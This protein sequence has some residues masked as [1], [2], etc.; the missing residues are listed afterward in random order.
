MSSRSLRLHCFFPSLNFARK[1]CL[2]KGRRGVSRENPDGA[3]LGCFL[4]SFR[5]VSPRYRADHLSRSAALL[6]PL[7]ATPS[8]PTV[9]VVVVVFFLSPHTFHSGLASSPP[10]ARPPKTQIPARCGVLREL[11]WRRRRSLHTQANL[12]F[13]RMFRGWW[14]LPGVPAAAPSPPPSILSFSGQTR[15]IE[16]RAPPETIDDIVDQ[17]DGPSDSNPL[18][19]RRRSRTRSL[20]SAYISI[21]RRKRNDALFLSIG[22]NIA[23]I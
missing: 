3:T 14:R 21:K 7:R 12:V 20:T 16:R 1:R 23:F 11:P 4:R 8:F 5:T 18:R 22:P 19:R 6:S 15:P 13:L 9:V 10:A 2:Q 17:D